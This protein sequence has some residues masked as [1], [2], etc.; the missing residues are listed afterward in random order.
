MLCG[1][2]GG[3]VCW[4]CLPPLCDAQ[5][6]GDAPRQGQGGLEDHQGSIRGIPALALPTMLPTTPP[7]PLAT[8]GWFTASV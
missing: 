2:R 8:G 7:L 6:C 1:G 4:S 3:E 5:S